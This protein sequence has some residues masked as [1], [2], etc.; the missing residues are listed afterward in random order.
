MYVVPGGGHHSSQE[1]LRS[2][3][4]LRLMAAGFERVE[5]RRFR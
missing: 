4:T 5:L 3:E 1:I 2:K